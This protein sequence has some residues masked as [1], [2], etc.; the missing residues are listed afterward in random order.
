MTALR[1]A[2]A[3]ALLALAWFA[4]RAAFDMYG[5]F[6]V[7]SEASQNAQN[8]R[9]RLEVQYARVSASV[10]QF[11]SPRGVE[12]EIRQRYG[13]SRPGEGELNII[14]P[15]AGQAASTTEQGGFFSRI[16]NAL[17]VW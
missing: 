8:E 15:Q 10:A 9:V 3:L 12:A 6:A 17:V 14:R 5:R 4:G 13:L 7:A 2:G 1:G 16:L 11:E